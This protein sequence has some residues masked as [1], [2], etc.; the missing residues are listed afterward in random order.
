MDAE[1]RRM[2]V[3]K[4][5]PSKVTVFLIP[6]I[7]ALMYSSALLGAP[8]DMPANSPGPVE[9]YLPKIIFA[10]P[11]IETNIYFDNSCLVINSANFA[12]DVN[13][14]KGMQRVQRWTFKPASA[15]VGSY[16]V[17]V[18]VRDE[19]NTVIARASSVIKVVPKDAGAGKKISLLLIGDSLTHQSVYSQHLLDLC[20]GDT[21]PQ[22]SLIGSHVLD[23]NHPDNRHEG[24]GG[25]TA[26]NFVARYTGI[27][28]TGDYRKRGSPFL[29]KD[30]DEKPHL[31]FAR[32]CKEFNNG[33]APNYV[34]ILLGANDVALANDG[35]IESSIDEMLSYYDT[36]IKMIH[37]FSPD[38]KVASLLTLAPAASQDAFGANYGCRVNR[39]QFKRNQHHLVMRLLEHYSNRENENIFV[40]GTDVAIDPVHG[41]PPDNALHPSVQGYKQV[42]DVIYSW[43]KASLNSKS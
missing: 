3:V 7:F 36:I 40:L 1:M 23:G 27:A 30:G 2:L 35:N 42:G 18:Y 15:D 28:R 32:Y 22:I 25:W 31:D 14:S 10:V 26:K 34:T 39:W 17:T 9:L 38:T 43:L 6:V 4:W 19:K 16:P 21:G 13:C 11:Q 8:G 5:S 37:D 12:F 24:Y 29:Y 41:Y 33:R 20:K